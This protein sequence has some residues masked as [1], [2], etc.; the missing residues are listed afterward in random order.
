MINEFEFYHGVTFA[1][2]LHAI[3]KELAI[4]PYS[5]SDKC[6]IC[7][8]R[9]DRHLYQ[10]LFEAIIPVALFLSTETPRQDPGDEEE[11]WRSLR[12]LGL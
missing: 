8:Q 11:C 2:M 10:V 12:S 3:Q 5:P 7:C 1:R 9:I 4:K 6:R